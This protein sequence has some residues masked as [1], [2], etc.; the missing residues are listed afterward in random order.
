MIRLSGVELAGMGVSV[1]IDVLVFV[2]CTVNVGWM[3]VSVGLGFTHPHR[4]SVPGRSTK[5]IT[6]IRGVDDLLFTGSSP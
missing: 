4:K 2:G 6:T 1:G 3:L 5:I